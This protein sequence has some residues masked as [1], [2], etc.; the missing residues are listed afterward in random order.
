M[1]KYIR[2][3]F[4]ISAVILYS[5]CNAFLDVKPEGKYLEKQAYATEDGINMS[6]NGIY[7]KMASNS[8]YGA[9]LTSTAV[10]V[11]AQRYYCVTEGC[12]FKQH[13]SYTYTDDEVKSTFSAIW[14]GVYS[15]VLNVNKFIENVEKSKVLSVAKRNIML[16]EAYGLRA[17]LHFDILRLYG[18]IYNVDPTADSIPYYTV[19]DAQATPLLAAN[20]VVDSIIRDL[21]RAEMLL[22]NDPVKTVGVLHG[23]QS[24]DKDFTTA[25]RNRRMNYYA[26]KALQARVYLY[27]GNKSAAL[28][29]ANEVIEMDR[30]T[31]F[32]PWI[33]LAR[34]SDPSNGDRLI[35]SEVLFGIQNSDMYTVYKSFFSPDLTD[36]AIL[37]PIQGNSSTANTLEGVFEAQ[38]NDWRYTISTWLTG[39]RGYKTFCKYADIT[40][41][42]STFRMFQPLIRKSEV[43]YIAAECETDIDT[44]FARLQTVRTHRGLSK[45]ALPAFT[46]SNLHNELLKEYRKEFWGEGQ[47]FFYYKRRNISKIPNSAQMS[48]DITMDRSKYVVPKPDSEMESR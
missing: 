38:T 33:S 31:T 44:A 7:L 28:V 17:F 39:P 11:L 22:V 8:T 29:A 21:N 5:S 1:K 34:I 41:N 12:P 15:T 19:A 4:A 13:A 23:F 9:S 25:F 42:D 48:G 37:R 45:D 43:Y 36:M 10:E 6:L 47:L 18:P 27:T 2:I 14:E 20:T 30:S 3:Y 35:S 32:F 26:I 46:E 40:S 24:T 16:G